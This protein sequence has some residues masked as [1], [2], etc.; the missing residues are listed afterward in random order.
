MLAQRWMSEEHVKRALDDGPLTEEMLNDKARR[1]LGVLEKA[2]LFTHPE[3]QPERAENKPQHRRILRE[4][5][6]KPL[7][8]SRITALSLSESQIGRSHRAYAQ[9]AQILGGGSHSVTPHYAVSPYEGIKNPG[10]RQDQG[11]D[12]AWM[13]HL[14]KSTARPRDI[15]YR[16]DAAD[17]ALACSTEQSLLASRLYRG[18]NSCSIRLV[19]KH[20]SP[21]LTTKHF[22]SA[23]KDS[24]LHRRVASLQLALAAVGWGKVYLDEKLIIDHSSD[25]TWQNSSRQISSSKLAKR[26]QSK[27]NISGEVIHA[28]VPALVWSSGALTPKI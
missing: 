13:L 16:G 28:G 15:V 4:A 21:K 22:L 18:H 8:C 10:R 9:A 6:R 19:R 12:C 5:A 7:S 25:K 3:L 26:T 27:L 24:L 23:W 11:G 2:G 14:Q 1:L 17:S 20:R